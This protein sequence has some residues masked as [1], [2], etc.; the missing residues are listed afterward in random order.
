MLKHPPCT[1][2]SNINCFRYKHVHLCPTHCWTCTKCFH[3]NLTFDTLL[4]P[5]YKVDNKRL[6]QYSSSGF[7]LSLNCE[8]N[9][10]SHVLVWFSQYS[11]DNR[12]IKM[13]EAIIQKDKWSKDRRGIY[14]LKSFTGH[15]HTVL[16]KTIKRR[17]EKYGLGW[18][19][20]QMVYKR[21]TNLKEMLLANLHPKVM[22][23][24]FWYYNSPKGL[25]LP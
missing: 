3:D 19:Q 7:D 20:L 17:R 1:A 16:H 9:L 12:D 2:F 6:L 25:K 15:W 18:L 4:I 5:H 13:A 24:C 10:K 8:L 14:L 11:L 21:H 22:H 23:G